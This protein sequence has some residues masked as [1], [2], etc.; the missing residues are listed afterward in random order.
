M[1]IFPTIHLWASDYDGD[2]TC[3]PTFVLTENYLIIANGIDDIQV[4]M[5]KQNPEIELGLVDENKLKKMGMT[6]E[7]FAKFKSTE[8]Q[9]HS[10]EMK[11]SAN[12]GQIIQTGQGTEVDTYFENVFVKDGAETDPKILM[13]YT[14][15]S[16][17]T[18]TDE[19]WKI[20]DNVLMDTLDDILEMTE[21]Y[22]YINDV[23]YRKVLNSLVRNMLKNLATSGSWIEINQSEIPGALNFSAENAGLLLNY[24]VDDTAKFRA[25]CK[26]N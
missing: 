12:T 4:L 13:G 16:P 9:K 26:I 2:Y 11:I 14:E 25:V 19:Y 17:K 21:T 7:D 8:F 3:E 18:F 1:T 10:F 23:E 22:E 5:T 6:P 24:N 20:R 15:Y